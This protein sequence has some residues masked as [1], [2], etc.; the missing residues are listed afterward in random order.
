MLI[1]CHPNAVRPAGC[2]KMEFG[3]K[4]LSINYHLLQARSDN[5]SI[6]VMLITVSLAF[7]LLTSP[8][9]LFRTYFNFVSKDTAYIQAVYHL[10]HHICHKLW[11]TNNAI[12][13]YLYCL[14]GRKFRQDLNMLWMRARGKQVTFGSSR[15]TTSSSL[16]NGSVKSGQIPFT[17]AL[18]NLP[19]PVAEEAL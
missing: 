19:K 3:Q 17:I 9:F 16:R 11:Y 8:L 4:N 2:F 18:S 15:E 6:T 5:N 12:N 7:V 10:G 13:F 14:T 1:S